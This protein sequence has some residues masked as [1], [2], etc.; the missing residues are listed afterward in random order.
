VTDRRAIVLPGVRYTSA[1][2]LLHFTRAV[3]ESNGWAVSEASWPTDDAGEPDAGQMVTEVAT[4]LIEAAGDARLLIV[5]KSIG[6]LAMPLAAAR[7]IAGIWMT[8]LLRRPAVMQ[9]LTELPAATLLVGSAADD[10]WDADAANRSG[11]QMLQLSDA[12]HGL[13]LDG[14]PLG[15]IHALRQVIEA[16]DHFVV[17][18]E[19]EEG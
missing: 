2:P 9:A 6:S 4:Q 5:V 10:T 7:G 19:P 1:H 13:E 8:P 12:N 15:S 17:G 11:H 16:V 14:D 3:L 18:I